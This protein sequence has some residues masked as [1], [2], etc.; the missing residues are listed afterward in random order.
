MDKLRNILNGGIS[1]V[2]FDLD[3]TLCDT[4]PDILAAWLGAAERMKIGSP[5]ESLRRY[6]IGPP[7]SEII[8]E[9][10]PGCGEEFKKRTIAA[11]A[12]LYDHSGFPRTLVYPGVAAALTEL[13][14]AGKRL[15]VVTNKRRTPTLLILEKLGL[16]AFFEAVYTMD[17][18]PGARSKDEMAARLLAENGIE[19]DRAAIVG[20]TAGDIRA[21]RTNRMTAVG[22]LWGY[23]KRAELEAAGA[24]ALLE[25]RDI[26]GASG[27]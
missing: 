23:G 4:A 24:D 8:E 11:F 3:G 18:T 17:S 9:L 14:R 26:S 22:V 12:E 7:L 27:A 1:A 6:R 20:D 5:E 19:P 15:F 25:L 21:G 2:L 10:V 16:A 13:K